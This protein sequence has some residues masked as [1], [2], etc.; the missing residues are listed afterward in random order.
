MSTNNQQTH[1]IRGLS[2]FIGEIRGCQ[3]KDQEIKVVHKEMA[4]IRKKF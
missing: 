3:T 4:K 2:L 1:G